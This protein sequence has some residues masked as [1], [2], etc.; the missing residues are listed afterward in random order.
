EISSDRQSAQAPSWPVDSFLAA[1]HIREDGVDLNWSEAGGGETPDRYRI[2]QNGS[3]IGIVPG[4]ETEYS[5]NGLQV[6]GRYT[7]KVEACY[8]S[9]EWS[10]DGPYLTVALPR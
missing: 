9:Q 1:S 8:S 6:G 10:Q 3:E 2:L 4:T 7:F 5:I